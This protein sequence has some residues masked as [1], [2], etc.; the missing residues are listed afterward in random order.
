MTFCRN[1][2]SGIGCALFD[3]NLVRVNAVCIL[4]NNFSGT[5]LTQMIY[6][7]STTETCGRLHSVHLPF[8]RVFEMTSQVISFTCAA[9]QFMNH[10]KIYGDCM[11]ARFDTKSGPIKFHLHS[12]FIVLIFR[13]HEKRLRSTRTIANARFYCTRL[14]AAHFFTMGRS[15]AAC[16]CRRSGEFSSSIFSNLEAPFRFYLPSFSGTAAD[17]KMHLQRRTIQTHTF[18]VQ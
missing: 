4:R 3:L 10:I 18:K 7:Q 13:S 6:R 9:Q 5:K 15:V 16:R 17:S 2:T 11:R 12:I 1:I 14:V 8:A